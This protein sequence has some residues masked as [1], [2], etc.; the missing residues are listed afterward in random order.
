MDKKIDPYD[1]IRNLLKDKE[2]S[3]YKII[4][5]LIDLLEEQDKKIK[6]LKE[7]MAYLSEYHKNNP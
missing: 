6:D 5:K 7:S 3:S 1:E 2:D 4:D